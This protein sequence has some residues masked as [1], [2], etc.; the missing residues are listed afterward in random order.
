MLKYNL[1]NDTPQVRA[2]VLNATFN[3]IIP[4]KICHTR[5]EKCDCNNI[6]AGITI[7]SKRTK[8]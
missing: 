2:V 3:S 1:K 4:Q 8:T 6:K 7:E 5:N